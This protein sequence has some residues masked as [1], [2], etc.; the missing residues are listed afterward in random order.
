MAIISLMSLYKEKFQD[1]Q[2]FRDQYM[3]TRK[4]CDEL[5]LNFA[6]CKDDA[7]AMLAKKGFTK[8]TN[9]QLKDGTDKVE[10]ELHSIIF[11]YKMDRSRYGKL[12]LDW[13]GGLLV[14]IIAVSVQ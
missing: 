10:E 8:P 7:R 3:A 11:M 5:G 14:I 2:E 9:A 1:I 12:I 6:R 13:L 4:V